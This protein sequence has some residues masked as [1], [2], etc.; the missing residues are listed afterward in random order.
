MLWNIKKEDHR[1]KYMED[2]I[3]WVPNWVYEAYKN[4]KSREFNNKM[5]WDKFAQV[6]NKVKSLDGIGLAIQKTMPAVGTVWVKTGEQV[7]NG[8]GF[9]IANK[10]FVTASHVVKDAG[11]DAKI[12]VTF[13]GEKLFECL[14]GCIN[15]TV[16]ASILIL[17]NEPPGIQPL[18]FADPAQIVVGEQVAVIGSPSGWHDVATT[19]IVS[20]INKDVEYTNDPTLKNMI[21]I[22]A[23]IE[24]GSSGSPVVDEDGNVIGIVMAL[25][26]EHAEI[27]VGQRAVTPI[28]KVIEMIQNTHSCKYV[29][30]CPYSNQ[31]IYSKGQAS[32]Y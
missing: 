17:K 30:N 23:D 5:N 27:G 14:I 16:D 12:Y 26:G 3:K 15:P 8:S 25:I 1:S 29:P 20:A 6:V 2:T 18:K 13:D 4:E 21:L 22:D 32:L 24:P 28:T 7:W 11:D 9:L 10:R 31:C 19:G